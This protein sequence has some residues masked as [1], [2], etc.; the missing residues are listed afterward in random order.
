MIRYK[1]TVSYVGAAYCGWQTQKTGNSVQEQI[2]SALARIFDMPVRILAAGRT[3]AGVNAR[4][5]VFQFDAE[6]EI[7]ER[8]LMGALNGFL[9]GDIRILRVEHKDALFHAR[10]CVKE[11]Q[12]DYRINFG[13]YDVFSK[14]YAYQCPYHADIERMK[15]AARYFVGTH[16][17]TS[18]NSNPLRETPDQVRTIDSITFEEEGSILK[19]SYRGR[20]FLRYMVRMMTAA[21][22][23]AGRGR[24]EPE[25]ISRLLE[26]KSKT[27]C[28]RNAHPEGLTLEKIEYFEVIAMTAS[29]TVREVLPEDAA[30]DLLRGTWVLADRHTDRLYGEYLEAAGGG[31]LIL[32]ESGAAEIQAELEA[33][34][35]QLKEYQRKR[36]IPARMIVLNQEE[37]QS[38]KTD[39]CGRDS[40]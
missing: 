1:C 40:A 5:Q 8:K 27:V 7:R 26:A 21:L 28:R 14:D 3:D 11:K 10:Y 12:Y 37:A 17:F 23:E 36:S 31:I 30:S 32:T 20:G 15:E 38:R 35:A 9:P 6:K 33:I 2:E 16:D 13:P 34:I 4:G 18:F 39:E 24:M 22:L 25:E 29:L 19:I